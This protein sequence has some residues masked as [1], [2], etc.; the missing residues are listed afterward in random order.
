MAPLTSAASIRIPALALY[1]LVTCQPRAAGQGTILDSLFTI[2][3][4]TIE[5][6]A[7]LDRISKLT[8]YSFTYDSRL[9]NPRARTGMDFRDKKLEF[10]LDAVLENDSLSYSI[11]DKYIIISKAIEGTPAKPDTLQ[12]TN[13]YNIAGIIVD[14]E[15]DEPLPFAS[16]VLRNSG[17]GIVAN[18]NGQFELKISGTIL[19]D[20]LKISHLGYASRDI[21]VKQAVGNNFIIGMKKDIIPIPEIIIKTR[22][23]GEIIR[24]TVS[25]IPRNYGNTPA[26]LTGFYREGVIKKESMQVY[27]E[28]IIK[29][30]KSPY[31]PTLLNDQVK[32]IRSRKI[33]NTDLRDTLS[34]RL[35]G[36]LS[37]CLELDGVRNYFDFLDREY[38]DYYS[39]RLTDIVSIDDEPVY[40]IDFKQKEEAGSPRYSGSLFVSADDYAVVH[41]DFELPARY[42]DMLRNAFISSSSRG[43]RTWPVSVKYSVSYREY[44]NRY[45]LSHVRGDLTFVSRKKKSFRS[46]F[47]VFF[48]LAI[49]HVDTVNVYRFDRDELAPVHSIFSRT[50]TGYDDGFWGDQDFLKPEENLLQAVKNLKVRLHE[51]PGPED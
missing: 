47:N 33:E 1:I 25:S 32:V 6:R 21:T 44:C 50:V 16:I 43:F 12:G 45:F 46:H 38:I 9:I 7:A 4:G 41:S 19:S 35:K 3:S 51:F 30:F 29:I 27:S 36:G 18:T 39:Y 31:S 5:T 24:K 28:A 20:T 17:K 2:R 15:T 14:D 23:P 8:G 26:I 10:I 22:L 40:Q 13:S 42:L 49:T 34:V 11:I 48:E 37:T